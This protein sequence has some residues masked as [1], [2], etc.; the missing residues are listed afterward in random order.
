MA[1]KKLKLSAKAHLPFKTKNKEKRQ[2]LHINRKR[3]TDSTKRDERFRRRREEDKN[4]ALR[5]QRL[6]QNVPLTLERKRVWDDVDGDISDGLG[7]S[8]DVERLKRPNIEEEQA[9]SEEEEEDE[10]EEGSEDE[11]E[12][13]DSMIDSASED[14]AVEGAKHAETPKRKTPT[15]RAASPIQSTRSTNLDFA[16]EAL[17]AKFPTLFSTDAPPVPKVLI[18][19]SFHSTLHKEAGHLTSLFPHSVYIPRSSH[20]Y[21][22]QFSVREICSFAT[23]Y[24]LHFGAFLSILYPNETS[25]TCFETVL[26]PSLTF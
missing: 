10:G 7:L 4:P 23:K 2:S 21:S 1:S 11:D 22:H 9:A 16:P 19:T 15:E 6:K 17:A 13:R 26:L 24:V 3:A 25:A 8:V 12:E 18:T 5:E 14:E 20:R